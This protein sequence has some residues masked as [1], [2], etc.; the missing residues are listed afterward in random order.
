ML[1]DFY[2][3]LLTDKQ[4]EYMKL[5]FNEDFSL[6]EIAD[7]FQVSRSAINDNIHRT[8]KQ[9]ERYEEVLKLL[10]K[11]NQKQ[12]IYQKMKKTYSDDENIDEYINK[13]QDLE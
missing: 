9:L 11:F 7:Q 6:K 10:N 3:G 13:L 8:I 1:L 2:S 5:Y 12:I 4:L